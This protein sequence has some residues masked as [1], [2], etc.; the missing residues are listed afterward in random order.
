MICSTII[1]AKLFLDINPF[2]YIIGYSTV[3]RRIGS[4]AEGNIIQLP[5]EHATKLFESVFLKNRTFK[6]FHS[7]F[8]KDGIKFVPERVRISVYMPPTDSLST[9]R[10][11]PVLLAIAP[12][13][14]K[15]DLKSDSHTAVSIVAIAYND[16]VGLAY[17]VK[18]IVGHNPFSTRSFII[19]DLDRNGK[20]IERII[21]RTELQKKSPKE[22]ARKVGGPTF[23]PKGRTIIPALSGEDVEKLSAKI[24]REILTDSYEKGMYPPEAI[25]S[26]L[27]DTP[28]VR[29]W[30]LVESA[31]HYKIF[32]AR[33]GTSSSTSCN[34]CTSTSTSVLPI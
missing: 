15:I 28:L 18:V 29:K 7:K 21:D 2:I 27:G 20:I 8:S 16:Q 26:L 9:K 33:P 1:S 12:G 19:M 10:F 17:A 11:A 5:A 30:S 32:A 22:I 25:R 14:S 31:R 13:I 4:I 23:V 24:Y 34:A 3:A 6:V